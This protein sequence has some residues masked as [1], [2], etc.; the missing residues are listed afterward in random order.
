MSGRVVAGTDGSPGSHNAVRWAAAR[1]RL[2]GVG[3]TVARALPERPLPSR[4]GALRALRQGV[5]FQTH[6]SGIAQRQLEEAADVARD[7]EPDLD[8]ETVLLRG[9]S[10]G[11]LAE[12]TRTARL[13]VIGTTGASGVSGIL[14]GGT[15]AGVVQHAHGPVVVV[16]ASSGDPHGPVT[17]GLDDSHGGTHVA[18]AAFTEANASGC[19]LLAIHA[20]DLDAAVEGLMPAVLA[21]DDDISRQYME[22]LAEILTEA[23]GD[24]DVETLTRVVWGRAE[25][26]LA[27]AS[28]AASLVVVGSRGRGGFAGLLLGSVSR[29]LIARSHCPTMVVRS[30]T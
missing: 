1:A 4:A 10:A 23:R 30:R 26:A 13:L 12:V 16:P 24:L 29:S 18:R 20:W 7:A 25:Q 21:E 17:L 8:V 14:L 27:E 3:L 22:M 19:P 11:A 6:L 5:D 9:D 2:H 15:A 28:R